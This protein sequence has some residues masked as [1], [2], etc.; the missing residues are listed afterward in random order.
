MK[1]VAGALVCV[2]LASAPRLAVAAEPA[3]KIDLSV[4]EQGP[5]VARTHHVHEGFYLRVSL[6]VGALGTDYDLGEPSAESH[7]GTLGLDV[8][9][10]GTPSTG[11][12]IGG[13]LLSE[14]GVSHN[15]EQGGR[16]LS[17]T[18]VR[19]TLLG[20]FVDGFFDPKGGFHLGGAV[21]LAA[22]AVQ[23]LKAEDETDTLTGFGGAAW[24]GYDAWV[25]R[26]WAMGGL[27]RVG[28]AITR[29]S[30]DSGDITAQSFSLGLM[31]TVLNH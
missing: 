8:L 9:V 10:G 4:P 22:L 7:G 20:P 14:A 19:L 24:A 11:L 30:A 23:D 16:S 28:G 5:P 18:N 13:A 21:G 12:A 6:G 29:K 17:D 1:V 31:L 27:V 15:V 25:A 3:P 2:L 26:E